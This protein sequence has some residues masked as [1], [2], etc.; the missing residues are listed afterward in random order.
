MEKVKHQ[1]GLRNMY[2]VPRAGN[3][4]L[5]GDL[6]FLWDETIEARLMSFSRY[7]IDMEIHSQELG[8]WFWVT[9]FYGEPTLQ[10]RQVGWDM[11]QALQPR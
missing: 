6:A 7:H 8:P 4:G 10:H 5:S 1:L 3:T 9:G 11:L 2:V